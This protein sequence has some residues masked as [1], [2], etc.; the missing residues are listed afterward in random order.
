M[1]AVNASMVNSDCDKYSTAFEREALVSPVW[2]IGEGNRDVEESLYVYANRRPRWAIQLCRM[3]GKVAATRNSTRIDSKDLR[4]VLPKYSKSRLDDLYREH[5]HQCDELPL[6]IE[7]FSYGGSK[8]YSE[9]LIKFIKD[10]YLAYNDIPTIDGLVVTNVLEIM[11]FLY[12]IGFMQIAEIQKPESEGH[13]P[14]NKYNYHDDKPNLVNVLDFQNDRSFFWAIHKSY[15]FA[16][17]IKDH[18]L[19]V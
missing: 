4:K 9:N 10:K 11:E 5:R 19:Q 1:R 7:S 15:H 6:I 2:N 12:R 8:F 16:L 13:P 18:R 17:D 3:A 14:L